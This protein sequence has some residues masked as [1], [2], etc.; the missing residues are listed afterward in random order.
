M[1]S[2]FLPAWLVGMLPVLAMMRYAVSTSIVAFS[3]WIVFC[4]L[5][6][7]A[8]PI[9]LWS[10][11]AQTQKDE[12]VHASY[13]HF[14]VTGLWEN[15]FPVLLSVHTWKHN[16]PWTFP[17]HTQYELRHTRMTINFQSFDLFGTRLC[18]RRTGRSTLDKLSG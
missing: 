9:L 16:V 18:P 3:P 12:Q 14:L 1:V 2:F 11:S 5:E 15:Q 8:K 4:C 6:S 10:L 7:R 13:K 17:K